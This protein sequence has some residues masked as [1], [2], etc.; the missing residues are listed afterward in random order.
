MRSHCRRYGPCDGRRSQPRENNL[1]LLDLLNPLDNSSGNLQVFK[2]ATRGAMDALGGGGNSEVGSRGAEVGSRN[3]ERL[4]RQVSKQVE[5]YVAM[6]AKMAMFRK[7]Q[8]ML[9]GKVAKGMWQSWI[10]R[11]LTTITIQV[12]FAHEL[13]IAKCKVKTANWSIGQPGKEEKSK[14]RRTRRDAEKGIARWVQCATS[15]DGERSCGGSRIS[16]AK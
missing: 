10:T 7:N 4:V 14:P 8:G 1:R 9:D 2:R 6:L 12:K 13:K 15:A 5:K 16:L 3:K 11:K